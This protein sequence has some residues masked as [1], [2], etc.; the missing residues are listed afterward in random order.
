MSPTEKRIMRPLAFCNRSIIAWQQGAKTQ[1]RRLIK[2][3]PA[4]GLS[5]TQSDDGLWVA[6]CQRLI[7]LLDQPYAVGDI[8]WMREALKRGRFGYT[9]YATDP[10]DYLREQDVALVKWW[11]WKR[12]NLPAIF[13]PRWACRYYARVVSVRP[14]RLQDISDEDALAE[15]TG[16]GLDLPPLCTWYEGM[17]GDVYCDWWDDLHKKPGTRWEDNPWVWVYELEAVDGS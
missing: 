17:G 16:V 14:E 11:P 6:H 3:Q 2:P 8:L 12:D 5:I 9:L 13:M 4:K 1:T 15:G 10:L 7:E